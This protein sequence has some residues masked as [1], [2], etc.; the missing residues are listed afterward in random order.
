[1]SGCLASLVFN[2]PAESASDR[3]CS[4]RLNIIFQIHIPITGI[5]IGII[6][7]NPMYSSRQK[8]FNNIRLERKNTLEKQQ[9]SN[10]P[11]KYTTESQTMV[12]SITE[13]YK[14][15]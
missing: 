10:S 2:G 7:F 12:L 13:F 1:M 3:K 9:T 11:L 5:C 14:F 15:I 4:Q 8:E 6:I